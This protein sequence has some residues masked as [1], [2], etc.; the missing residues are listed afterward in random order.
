MWSLLHI[1]GVLEHNAITLR[2]IILHAAWGMNDN[3]VMRC[4]QENYKQVFARIFYI[5]F[6][7]NRTSIKSLK[8]G[9]I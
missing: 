3:G 4:G 5:A 6:F 1:Q 2:N 8:P 7:T 9:Y